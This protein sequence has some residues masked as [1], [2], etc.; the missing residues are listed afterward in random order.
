MLGVRGQ[1]HLTIDGKGRV[2]LP[3]KLREAL[4]GRSYD[5][6]ILTNYKGS[7][8][9]Y[10]EDVWEKYEA[11]LLNESP[12]EDNSLLFTRAFI[13]GASECNLDKQGRIL[14]PSYLRQYAGLE[15]EL[16][17]IS[18]IDRLEIWSQSRWEEAYT[19]AITALD[20]SG[21]VGGLRFGQS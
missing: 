12:F 10:T 21:G 9:G 16:V 11:Q 1:F 6:L 19:Q 15:R 3:R 7:I 5:N 13:A 18:V 4:K 20:Q 2:S 17:L 14:I 8:W